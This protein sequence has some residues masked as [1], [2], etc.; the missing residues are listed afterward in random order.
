[1]S[2]LSYYF[3]LSRWSLQLH[4]ARWS[5]YR[6]DVLIWILAIWLTLA[7]QATFIYV[8]NQA[9]PAGLFGYTST[10]LITFFAIAVL[11]TGLAQMFVIGA[12][13]HMAKAVWIGQFDYWLIQPPS[14][15]M[16]IL[17]EDVG[18]LWFCPHL[19]IGFILLA[20]FNPGQ[21]GI[22][23]LAA[24]LAAL[25]EVGIVLSF[26]FPCIKWG[27]WNPE[28]GLWEYLENAR[29]APILRSR[30]TL[31]LIASFG[32][33]QYSIAIEVI[34]GKLSLF[35]LLV[36]AVASNILAYSLLKY[37]VHHYTSASS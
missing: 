1:M 19:F 30:N 26:C 18:V 7:I 32:V 12:V 37:L 6:A 3:R 28:D 29:S 9:S 14:L 5:R 11:A 25:F 31:L 33:I 22:S 24:G 20:I 10:E 8:T 17:L 15:L 4:L 21:L 13:L 35:F 2:A 36:L 23:L 27:R 16:R 34:S